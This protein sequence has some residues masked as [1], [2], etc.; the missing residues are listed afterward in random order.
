MY[1]FVLIKFISARRQ[2]LLFVFL[3]RWSHCVLLGGTQLGK[4]MHSAK[5]RTIW[6]SRVVN[7]EPNVNLLKAHLLFSACQFCSQRH[8]LGLPQRTKA[9]GPDVPH[10]SCNSHSGVTMQILRCNKW[11]YR[12]DLAPT[13]WKEILLKGEEGL[14][15]FPTFSDDL[16]VS[17]ILLSSFCWYS[18]A[19][20]L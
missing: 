9:K 16:N 19:A 4:K 1:P 8:S 18:Y 15:F 17:S 11:V 5:F 3:T 12:K 14:C 10:A 20:D 7:C 6:N 2:L 13:P